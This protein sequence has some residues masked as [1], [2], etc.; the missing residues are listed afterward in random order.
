LCEGRIFVA[1]YNVLADF[2]STSQRTDL[3]TRGTLN[4]KRVA[5]F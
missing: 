4:D 2:K 5:D 3:K 1:D